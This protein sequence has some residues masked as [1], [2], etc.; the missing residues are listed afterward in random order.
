MIALIQTIV[1]AL[2]LYWWVII[3]SAIFSWLYAFNVV[4]SRNQFVGTIG[5]ML[6]RLT[7]PALRPIRRFMP[8]LGGI[9]ISPIILLLIIFFIRQFLL[10]TVLSLVA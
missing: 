10:T 6:Y 5:N 7:E 8:D 9:D 4:N 1:M 2:D 3:A